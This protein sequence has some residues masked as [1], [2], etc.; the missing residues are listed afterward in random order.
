MN[1][2]PQELIEKS[3]DNARKDFPYLSEEKIQAY[4]EQKKQALRA[5]NITINKVKKAITLT[6]DQK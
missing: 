3:I 5:L 1:T 6:L 2:L 4:I